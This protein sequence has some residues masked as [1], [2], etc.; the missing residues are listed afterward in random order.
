MWP[1]SKPPSQGPKRRKRKPLCDKNP[2]GNVLLLWRTRY[3]TVRSEY[4]YVQQP[5]AGL[6]K[7][8]FGAAQPAANGHFRRNGGPTMV[9]S[10]AW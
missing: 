1:H 8:V 10:C 2:K 5:A 4:S 6:G 7:G 3:G 9:E